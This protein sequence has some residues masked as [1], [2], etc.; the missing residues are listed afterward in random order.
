MPTTNSTSSP[1]D[2]SDEITGG[3]VAGVLIG[4]LSAGAMIAGAYKHHQQKL[5]GG[6]KEKV[7]KEAQA[8]QAAQTQSS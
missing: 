7:A 2:T 8:Q 1:T 3:A 6:S 5:K 4:I